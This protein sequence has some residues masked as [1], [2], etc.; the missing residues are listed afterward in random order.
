MAKGI[1]LV[2][3]NPA[4]PEQ[5]DEYN[6]WYNNVHLKEVLTVDGFVSARRFKTVNDDGGSQYVAIYEI[7]GDPQ[8]AMKA[9]GESTGKFNMSASLQLDPPPQMRLLETI[10]DTDG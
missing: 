10:F 7:D 4:S 8:L 1:L 3:T 6:D 5:E 2:S 9:L